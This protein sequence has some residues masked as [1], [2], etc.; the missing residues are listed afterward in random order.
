MTPKRE[1][2]Q[3]NY[4]AANPRAA[5][6]LAQLVATGAI[7]PGDKASEWYHHQQHR[8]VFASLDIEKFRKRMRKPLVE[9]YGEAATKGIFKVLFGL[10]YFALVCLLTLLLYSFT[11]GETSSQIFRGSR[12][13]PHRR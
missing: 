12:C 7:K 3:T 1:N 13:Q 8:A 5:R 2:P 10:F 9:K 4:L 11:C 6:H